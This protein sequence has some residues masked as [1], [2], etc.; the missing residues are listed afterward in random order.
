MSRERKKKGEDAKELRALAKKMFEAVGKNAYYL[1]DRAI[2]NLGEL[3]ENLGSF[4]EREVEWLA[5]WIEY[6]G[7]AVTAKKIRRSTN[8]FKKIVSRR[9]AQLKRH[10]QV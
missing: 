7:D 1:G 10:Y 6:L 4:T 2:R 5:S 9:H 8:N 3:K